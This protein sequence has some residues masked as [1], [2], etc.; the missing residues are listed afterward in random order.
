MGA[1]RGHPG[2]GT[3]CLGGGRP[4]LGALPPPTARPLG[5]LLGPTTHWLW[6]RGDAG[7]GTR[8]KPHSTRSCE[9]ALRAVGAASGCPGGR[10]LPGCGASG[11]G[12]STTLDCPPSGRAAGAHY[13]LAVGAGGCGHGDPSP[14][15]QRALFLAGFARCGGGTRAP[16][17]GRLLP[18]CGASGVGRSPT[19][20]CPPSGRAAGA[21]YPLA[22]G[23]GGCGRGDLSPT[24]QR[25]LLRA[26]CARCWAGMWLPGGE[27]LLPGCGASGVGR[28]PT[29]DC[30][31]SGWAAGAHYPLAVGAGGRRRGDP[32]PT[33][34]R[35]LL[36]AVFSALWGRHEGARGGRLLPGCGASW[37][38]RSPT[39]DCP[40]FGLAAG[41][42]CVCVPCLGG[43]GRPASRARFG[44]PHLSFGLSCFALC[45][46]GPLRAGVALFVVVAA[47]FF[48]FPCCFSPSPPRCAP[49]VSCFACFPAL[50]A[51]GLGVLSPP[52]LLF[53]FSSPPSVRPV[54]TCF[55]C[56]PAWGA[57][58]LGVLLP[59][60]LPFFL[61][62]LPPPP[63]LCP[64]PPLWRFLLSGCLWPLRPHPPPFFF[65]VLLLFFSCC[66]SAVCV[67]GCRAVCSLSCPFVV[68]CASSV[69]FLVAGV[70][71]SWCRCLLLGV[72]WWLW[73]PGVVVWW[74]V[75]ALVPASGLDVAGRPPCGVPFPCAVSCG[76]VLPCGAVL[77]C[78]VFF[79][80]FFSLLVVL[81][82]CCSPL[83]L[84]S[85]PV[86]GRF[87][88]CAL[89]VRCCAGVPAPLLSV[90]C[91]LALV[92]LAGVLCCCLLCLC[93]C[94]WAWLSS[95]VS[96]WVLVAP[97]VVSRWRAVVCPRVLCCAVL[98]RVVLP[99]VA[100][101]CAVLFRFAPFGAAARC[102]VSWGAVL[103]LG[104]LCLLAPCFVLSPRAVFVLL[105]CVAAW[106]CSPLC[107]VPCAPWGVVLC[108]SC[109]LRPV[110]CCC[111]ARS[112]SVPCF[113][114]LCPV[115]LCCRVVPWCP[116]LPPCWVCSLRGCGCTYLKN[117]CKIS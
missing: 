63:S 46:F 65:L 50:D 20:D 97:G 30:P 48:L 82:S 102:V 100:L 77:W 54:V 36:R 19:P 117:R 2:G 25:A 91:S 92:G 56:F 49:V 105:W 113:P 17:E 95:V 99:G 60:P 37:V 74:C 45:L 69:R 78:P 18:G 8:H 12:R 84:S 33:P 29:P 23:A 106:C 83:V 115:V 3:S 73:L 6:V 76:A 9:L 87:C 41:L 55:A 27:R 80:L 42:R 71:G 66:V 52:P 7:M 79:F 57:L 67:L 53:F 16:G 85:G 35:A 4:G 1:A 62:F 39:P 111:V 108:V 112:P 22:V 10:L 86:P 5:G 116:V 40:P 109:R 43:S 114:V 44:A 90:R 104:V 89:P 93:V 98:L 64:P 26:G 31:P 15:P 94:C 11:V 101:L 103:R 72:C 51:L 110:R 13:P 107:F 47:F 24:P 70:V 68:L 34:Q 38:G 21:H 59:P 88:F 81:V 61:I 96:W 75:S 32:S 28:S 58:G 14:T